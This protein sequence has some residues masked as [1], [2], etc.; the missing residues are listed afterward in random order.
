MQRLAFERLDRIEGRPPPGMIKAEAGL[1]E[2]MRTGVA[3]VKAHGHYPVGRLRLRSRK[4]YGA[5]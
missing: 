1:L 5:E 4:F 2:E 3:L